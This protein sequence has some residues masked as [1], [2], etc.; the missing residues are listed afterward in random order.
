MEFLEKIMPNVVDYWPN[1]LRS[2]VETLKVVS[3]SLAFIIVLGTI[4]GIVL[5]V[6]AEGGLYENKVLDQIVPKFVNLVRSVPFVILLTLI[7]PFTRII[8]GT[9]IGVKGAV[10]PLIVGLTPFVSRQV[11]L[12]I[13]EIDI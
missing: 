9:A 3:V 12:A 4:L 10:V 11:E 6:I 8:V 7:M 13:L 1:F 2:I 5:V